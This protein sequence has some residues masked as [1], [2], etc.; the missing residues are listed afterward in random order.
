STQ[1]N[2]APNPVGRDP[3]GQRTHI[4]S[5][6]FVENSNKYIYQK[7]FEIQKL[8]FKKVFG[9]VWGKAPQLSPR[10]QQTKELY[11]ERTRTEIR[12]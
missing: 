2:F 5:A 12:L 10:Q 11:H 8:S 7:F 6:H 3:R 1:S 4:N 9:G